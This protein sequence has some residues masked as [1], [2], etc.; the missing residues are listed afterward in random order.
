MNPLTD[1]Y[2]NA[3]GKGTYFLDD[4][5]SPAQ[6]FATKVNDRVF[7]CFKRDFVRRKLGFQRETKCTVLIMK[8][9][10]LDLMEF[11][12]KNDKKLV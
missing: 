11:V 1:I 8:L 10:M 5:E 7:V 3:C 9:N 2:G 4:I 12:S 6:R